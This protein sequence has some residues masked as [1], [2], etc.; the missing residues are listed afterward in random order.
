[1]GTTGAMDQIALL[2]LRYFIAV[3]EEGTV[4]AAADRLGISQPSLS[5]QITRLERR[6][7]VRLFDRAATGMLPTDA[8]RRLLGIATRTLQAMNDLGAPASAVRRIGVPRGTDAGVLEALTSR[9]GTAIEFVSLDTSRAQRA[10]GRRVDAAVVRGPIAPARGVAPTLLRIA[11]LG[12]LV[13]SGHSLG[14]REEIEWADLDGLSLLW[15]DERRAPEYAAWLLNCCHEHGWR[16]RLRVLDPAGTQLVADALRREPDLIALR[17]RQEAR[18]AG[19]SWVRL[20][21]PPREELLLLSR[22]PI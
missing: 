1:M 17:P 6:L 22:A 8:G 21:D 3:V 15:F 12:V 4:G 10:L 2:H 19:L 18:M 16:P 13:G 9:F 20:V 5:Q 7:G 14:D 11:P